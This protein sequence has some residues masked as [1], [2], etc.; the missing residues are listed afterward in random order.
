MRK[1][2]IGK[3]AGMSQV[4][5]EDG[6]AIPV[7][8][9]ESPDC[10]LV[11]KRTVDGRPSVQIGFDRTDKLNKPEAGHFESRG[12][13]PRR[14][15]EEFLVDEDSP[16]LE[17]EEGDDVGPD[18]FEEGERIDVRGRTKGR[19]FS[20]AM[21]RHGFSGG[22]STHGGGFGRSTGAV[23]QAAD[24]SRIFPGKKMPGRFGNDWRTIQNLEVV[25]VFPE[26][27]VLMVSGSIPGP[28]GG[29]VLV[30]DALKGEQ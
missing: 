15:L 14:V 10:V 2:L 12:V 22:P 11:L 30:H 25:S 20:G 24:P 5:D 26:D 28:D 4:F 7:T 16:L 23:G 8:M 17:M 6:N 3:K 18:L 1:L 19:G 29:V 27:R 13:E 21:K 9:V